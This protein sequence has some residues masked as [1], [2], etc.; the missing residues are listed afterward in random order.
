MDEAV[1]PQDT[2]DANIECVLRKAA[3]T[4]RN[5]WQEN[6]GSDSGSRHATTEPGSWTDYNE[7]NGVSALF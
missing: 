1:R 7:W 2:G 5:K 3:G 4:E 6:K